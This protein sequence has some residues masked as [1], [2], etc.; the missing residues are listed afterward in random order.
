MDTFKINTIE[1]VMLEVA[2]VHLTGTSL[3]DEDKMVNH[4]VSLFHQSHDSHGS[5]QN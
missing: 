5:R 1:E 4:T 2:E 3:L